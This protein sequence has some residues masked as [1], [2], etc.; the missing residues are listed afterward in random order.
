MTTFYPFLR[1]FK[2]HQKS[3]ILIN[4]IFWFEIS[5]FQNSKFQQFKFQGLFNAKNL[6]NNF[7]PF[8]SQNDRKHSDENQLKNKY[9]PKYWVSWIET[10]LELNLFKFFTKKILNWS[11]PLFVYHTEPLPYGKNRVFP[12][13]ETEFFQTHSNDAGLKLKWFLVMVLSCLNLFFIFS[14]SEF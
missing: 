13:V 11:L 8:L 7:N 6:K 9:P 10:M 1:V 5:F 4:R 2:N 14:G 12:H 3:S